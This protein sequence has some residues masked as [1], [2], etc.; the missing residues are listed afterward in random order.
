MPTITTRSSGPTFH[1]SVLP[2]MYKVVKV[3]SQLVVDF[4]TEGEVRNWMIVLAEG[5]VSSFGIRIMRA[6]FY[7]LGK[8][9]TS[10]AF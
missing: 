5:Q 1:E 9:T 6:P 2:F 4:G 7:R 3:S 8:K 10:E